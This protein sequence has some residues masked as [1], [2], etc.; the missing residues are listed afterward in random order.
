MLDRTS[1]LTSAASGKIRLFRLA[2]GLVPE[3]LA[4]FPDH[5]VHSN[6]GLTVSEYGL[7]AV[8][9]WSASSFGVATID[10]RPDLSVGPVT[11]LTGNR[12]LKH[13]ADVSLEGILVDFDDREVIRPLPLLPEN[14]DY[15][16]TYRT[17]STYTELF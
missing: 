13:A 1:T 8:T 15:P 11:Y 17:P 10:V 5:H 12:S 3:L 7:V 4:F 16:V 9:G 6:Y 14:I 2:P